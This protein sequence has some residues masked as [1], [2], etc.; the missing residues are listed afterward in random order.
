MRVSKNKTIRLKTKKYFLMKWFLFSI[1]IFTSSFLFAQGY[2]T[3]GGVRMGDEFGITVQQKILKYTT[4]EGLLQSG[5]RSKNTTLTVLLEQ[6]KKIITKGFNFYFGGGIHKT[7][8]P[9]TTPDQKVNDPFGVT[10]VIG[11][12]FT[13]GKLNFSLDYKPQI[14]IWGGDQD[15]VSHGAFSARYV[16]VKK[17]KKKKKKKN[18]DWKFW[19]K[20][21]NTKNSKKKKK[22]K[23]GLFG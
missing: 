2:V 11:A 18:Q 13:L 23:G 14:N 15:F 17:I 4:I 9:N 20:N 19:Q 3:A 8:V 10:G 7:W 5:I 1:L 12:E 6:H 16:F 22:K 21:K